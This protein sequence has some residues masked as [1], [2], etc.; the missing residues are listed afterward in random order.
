VAK[1]FRL[2]FERYHLARRQRP[3]GAGAFF[4]FVSDAGRL[5]GPLPKSSL[6]RFGHK[7]AQ[8]PAQPAADEERRAAEIRDQVP[9][10]QSQEDSAPDPS[11]PKPL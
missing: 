4:D 9:V 7:P 11:L 6:G 2:N 1:L 5:Y 8:E 10:K 3:S